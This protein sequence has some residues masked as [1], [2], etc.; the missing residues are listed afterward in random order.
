MK[1]LSRSALFPR[2][3]KSMASSSLILAGDDESNRVF[4]WDPDTAVRVQSWAVP[5]V[6]DI[7]PFPSRRGDSDEVA[8]LGSKNIY[9][10][11][12]RTLT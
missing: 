6:I 7:C 9:I 1:Q 2:P 8:L 4:V 10:A 5:E 11:E 12:L 3:N